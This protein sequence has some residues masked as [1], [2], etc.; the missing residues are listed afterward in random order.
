MTYNLVIELEQETDGRWI[1]EIPALSG[2]MGYGDTQ[3]QAARYVKALALRI[4]AEQIEGSKDMGCESLTILM[5]TVWKF[6]SSRPD[7]VLACSLMGSRTTGSPAGC[8]P[9]STVGATL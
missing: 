3:D 1:A 7:Q 8:Y 4:I 2:I 6:E 5:V 9:L